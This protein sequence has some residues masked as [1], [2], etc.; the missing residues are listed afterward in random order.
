M[1]RATEAP[2]QKHRPNVTRKNRHRRYSCHPLPLVQGDLD[3]LC[4]V[5]AM[6]N[7]IRLLAPELS[8]DD[9]KSLFYVLL[10]TLSNAGVELDEIV[11]FG[12]GKNNMRSLVSAAREFLR[13]YCDVGLTVEWLDLGGAEPRLSRIWSRLRRETEER[14]VA[15]VGLSGIHEHWTVVRRV[16]RKTM[17]LYDSDA[18]SRLNRSNCGVGTRARHRIRPENIA[19]LDRSSLRRA[20]R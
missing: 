7:A 15:I 6:I 11:A 17:L 12:I 5:Y 19:V 9:E 10:E 4:G 13:E 16:T 20:R 8:E 1:S 2:R 14:R 18:L 3:G